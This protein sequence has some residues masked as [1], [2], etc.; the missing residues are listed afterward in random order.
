MRLSSRRGFTLIE[1]LVVIAIIAVLIALLLPAVQA[2]REAARRSQCVNNLKQIG[3][4]MHNYQSSNGCF[5]QG[6]SQAAVNANYA[7]GYAGWTEWSAQAELLGYMEQTPIYNAINFSFCGGQGYGYKVNS[8]GA[9]ATINSFLC[10]SDGNARGAVFNPGGDNY[11]YP[12]GNNSYR[13]SIGTTTLPYEG[14]GPLGYADCQPNP[15]NIGG[16]PPGCSPYFNGVFGYWLTTDLRDITD[17]SSNTIAFAESLCGNPLNAPVRG[18]SVTGVTAAHTYDAQNAQTQLANGNLANALNQCT[19]TFTAG[20]SGTISNANGV[21]WGWGAVGMTLMN[22]VVP[23]SSPQYQW[24]ACRTSCGGCSPDDSSYS[25]AQSNHPGGAN[26][27]FADGS[28][29]FIKA[30]INMQ[31]YM[32]LGTRNGGEVVSADQY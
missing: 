25:N 8:T 17:G 20:A 26:V 31:T 13:G 22:T 15:L 12:P 23:P 30:T 19:A 21:R 24:N 1:L 14:G 11:S 28:V 29:K 5:P 10:P 2:A 6:K 3:L 18:N 9:F 7:G 32:A 4:G 16:G 27:M